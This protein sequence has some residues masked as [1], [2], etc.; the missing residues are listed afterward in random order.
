M[1]LGAVLSYERARFE[2]L[3]ALAPPG[4]S[5]QEIYRARSAG[6]AELEARSPV[7]V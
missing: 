4:V 3:C 7:S 1:V 5:A 2:D 6:R